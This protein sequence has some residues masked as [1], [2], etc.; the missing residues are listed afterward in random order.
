MAAQI[1]LGLALVGVGILLV[2]FAFSSVSMG[3]PITRAWIVAVLGIVFFIPG[4]VITGQGLVSAFF[5]RKQPAES[6]N[7]PAPPRPS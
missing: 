3:R 2:G 6:H 5:G 1:L 7:G 4:T